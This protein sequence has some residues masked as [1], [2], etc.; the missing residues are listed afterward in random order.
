VGRLEYDATVGA[1]ARF[2]RDY[3]GRQPGNPVKALAAVLNIAGIDEPP[4]R[5]LFGQRCR[6]VRRAGR[7]R[8]NGKTDRK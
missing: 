3:D 8:K 5:L 6:R 4:L 7:Y 1:T 2:Q